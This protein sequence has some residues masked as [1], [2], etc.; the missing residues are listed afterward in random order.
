MSGRELQSFRGHTS[1][2]ASVAFSPDGKTV[3]TG[4]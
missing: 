2:V 3:L 4:S 1:N